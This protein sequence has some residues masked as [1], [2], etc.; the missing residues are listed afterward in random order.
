GKPCPRE[1]FSNARERAQIGHAAGAQDGPTCPATSRFARKDH[2]FTFAKRAQKRV[3]GRSPASI[4]GPREWLVRVAHW[5]VLRRRK[6]HAHRP[7][8]SFNVNVRVAAVQR[9]APTHLF[10]PIEIYPLGATSSFSLRIR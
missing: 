4:R 5:G 10:I 2:R 7:H 3:A 6:C 9:S 1:A 8:S